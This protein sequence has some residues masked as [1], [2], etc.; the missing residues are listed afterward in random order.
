MKAFTDGNLASCKGESLLL[1]ARIDECDAACLI[2]DMAQGCSNKSYEELLQALTLV[3]GAWHHIPPNVKAKLAEKNLAFNMQA[4][5]LADADSRQDVC[6]NIIDALMP[7]SASGNS[8]FDGASPSMSAAV[9]D[10]L[11]RVNDKFDAELLGQDEE[12]TDAEAPFRN[13]AKD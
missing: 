11:S 13:Q 2:L 10:L 8:S 5:E 4:L 3:K 1:Q 12:I 6:N 9:Q 7:A